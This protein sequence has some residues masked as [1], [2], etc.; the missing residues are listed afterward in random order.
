M[1]RLLALSLLGGCSTLPSVTEYQSLGIRIVETDPTSLN[2]LAHKGA[3]HQDDGSLF[4]RSQS[5]RGFFV[6]E[7]GVCELW[8]SWDADKETLKHELMHCDES[9]RGRG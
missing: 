8:L 3:R 2:R 7:H 1:K 5:T 9:R 6:Y 4:M